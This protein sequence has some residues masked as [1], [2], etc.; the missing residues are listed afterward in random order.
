[1]I[2]TFGSQVASS[3][4]FVLNSLFVLYKP[5]TFVVNSL[6]LANKLATLARL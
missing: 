3:K 1:M 4:F 6:V 2:R 5:L